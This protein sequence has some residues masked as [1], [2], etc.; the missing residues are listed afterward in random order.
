MLAADHS[1][2]VGRFNDVAYGSNGTL[3]VAWYDPTGQDLKFASRNSSGTWS[4]TTTIDST[5]DVGTYAS[6][7]VDRTNHPAIA[8]YDAT[9]ADLK[10]AYFNGATWEVSTV[11]STGRVGMYPSLAFD[12]S[13][14]PA[15]TYYDRT[16]GDLKMAFNSAAG[17]WNF[18]VI[19]TTGDCGRY[20]SLASNPTTGRWSVVY[21]QTTN[22]L[23]R[24]GAQTKTGWSLTTVDDTQIGGGYTSLIFA[25]DSS[26]NYFP[27]FSYYDAFN[28][29]A[30][31]ADYINGG[32]N[33]VTIATKGTV[34]LYGNFLSGSAGASCYYFSKSANQ[35]VRAFSSDQNGA[36]WTYTTLKTGGGTHLSVAQNAARSVR[37]MV[38]LNT[39]LDQLIVSDVT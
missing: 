39:S 17:K 16:H 2:G 7:A 9:N 14:N 21:E 27:A 20:S 18:S 31:A 37:T 38:W 12:S 15:V 8:Y 33:V 28:G 11:D 22:G 29:D 4:S 19:D 25:Q 23:F 32:W 10:T 36:S 35:V 30:K 3:Y 26:S 24:Y 13:G 6:L 34:G 1:L 5:G